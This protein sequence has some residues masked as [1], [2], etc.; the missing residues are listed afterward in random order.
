MT[1]SVANFRVSRITLAVLTGAAFLAAGCAPTEETADSFSAQPFEILASPSGESWIS[2]NG[3]GARMLFGRHGA[4]WNDHAVW[5]SVRNG[6][7]WSEPTEAAFSG[8]YSDRGARFYPALDA[9]VFSSNRPLSSDD[10]TDD[11]NIWITQ[12]DG[13]EWSAPEP[14][15]P[16][17]TEANEIHPS[18]AA[19]GT[20]WF[21]SDREGT[22]GRSDLWYARLGATGYEVRQAPAPLNSEF[23]E[24]DSFIEPDGRYIIFSRTDDPNGLGGDDLYISRRSGDAWTEPV[25]LGAAVNTPEYEYGPYVSRNGRTLFFT[26]HRGGTADIYTIS[27]DELPVRLPA[28]LEESGIDI[29]SVPGGSP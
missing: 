18:V 13:E 28:P 12:F 3:S 27:V 29:E 7:T 26:S 9:V 6:G 17:N 21:S 4:D 19:D 15:T 20:I 24:A 23:S 8:M 16:L 5:E 25:N 2:F 1:R 11:F 22:L 14:M 10:S